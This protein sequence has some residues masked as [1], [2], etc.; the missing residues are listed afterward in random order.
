M[1]NEHP[2]SSWVEEVVQFLSVFVFGCQHLW[3][4]GHKLQWI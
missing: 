1:Q 2:V 3:Q 4:E